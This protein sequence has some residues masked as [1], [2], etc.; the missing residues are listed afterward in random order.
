MVEMESK[1]GNTILQFQIPWTMPELENLYMFALRMGA[2]DV[3]D[4]VI[5]RI[6]EELHRP[7]KRVLR[8]EDGDIETFN[9]LGFSASFLNYISQHDAQGFELFTDIIVM[10]AGA[11]QDTLEHLGVSSLHDDV[12]LT[13][14]KKFASEET[15]AANGKNTEMVCATYH[16]HDSDRGCHKSAAL[17][18]CMSNGTVTTVRTASRPNRVSKP[19]RT[20]QSAARKRH[21]TIQHEE[22]RKR[23][24][25][26]YD[27]KSEQQV[28]SDTNPDSSS[29]SD[30]QGHTK[31]VVHLPSE[32]TLNLPIV[33]YTSDYFDHTPAK[34]YRDVVG[35]DRS[36][37]RALYRGEGMNQTADDIEVA[38]KKIALVLEKMELFRQFGYD[39][40]NLRVVQP[41]GR[42]DSV[43]DEED[44]DG[45]DDGSEL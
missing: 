45:W 6:H 27:E 2:Y 34:P 22:D 26:H 21:V 18:R 16:H 40:D 14:I 36:E 9:V 29:D 13:L 32:Y 38:H 1:D 35:A 25:R 28:S 15:S 5:D 39:I 31:V 3:C 23:Q 30:E 19:K 10:E 33:D 43:R 42:K 44:G 41:K 12:K 7:E 4:M 37:G 17:R 8:T 20:D 24:R 11:N